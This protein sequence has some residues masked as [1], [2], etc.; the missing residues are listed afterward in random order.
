MGACLWV[1]L[2]VT[3]LKAVFQ[4]LLPGIHFSCI[5]LRNNEVPIETTDETCEQVNVD[6]HS[7]HILSS[8]PSL[9]KRLQYLSLEVATACYVT[10]AIILINL[11]PNHFIN[12]KYI[13]CPKKKQYRPLILVQFRRGT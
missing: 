1:Y 12:L 7:S 8:L 9:Q 5:T 6:A 13:Q 10:V 3:L 11:K 4:G 2:V